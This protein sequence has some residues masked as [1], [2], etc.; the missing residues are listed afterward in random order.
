MLFISF[1]LFR[2]NLEHYDRPLVFLIS[3][4]LKILTPIGKVIKLLSNVILTVNGLVGC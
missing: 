4:D 2:N 3:L 1:L